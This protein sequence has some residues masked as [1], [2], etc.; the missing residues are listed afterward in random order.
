MTHTQWHAKIR[1]SLAKVDR[2]PARALQSLEQLVTQVRSEAAKAVGEWHVEQTLH[3]IS[4]V[5]S[6]AEEHRE[7]A[8][9]LLQVAD[10][11]ERHAA[12]YRRA[13]V[14]ACATAA[15]ELASAGDR[16]AAARALRRAAA[17]AEDL[18]PADK[19]FR[20]AQ[21]VVSTMRAR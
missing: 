2:Q 3:L 17:V 15:L 19:L 11:H 8:R 1:Q 18:R 9:T 12:Y 10:R 7:S 6:Q 20:K 5:Q 4:T 16:A 13:F 21:R 14:S